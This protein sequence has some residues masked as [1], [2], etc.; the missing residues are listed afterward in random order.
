MGNEANITLLHSSYDAGTGTQHITRGAVKFRLSL[1]EADRN[2]EDYIEKVQY[3]V[4]FNGTVT[5]LCFWGAASDI[6]TKHYS[7]GFI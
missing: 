1:S 2:P 4:I 7:I 3:T 5:L 6:I